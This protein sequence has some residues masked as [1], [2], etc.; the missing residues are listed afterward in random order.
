MKKKHIFTIFITVCFCAIAGLSLLFWKTNFIYRHITKIKTAIT[1]QLDYKYRNAANLDLT[2]YKPLEDDYDAWYTKYHF[3]AHAGGGVEGMVYTQSLEAWEQSY[4]NGVRVFDADLNFTSD[5]QL[6]LRH[7]WEDDLDDPWATQSA[8]SRYWVDLNG[9]FRKTYT[10]SD[11]YDIP[12]YKTFK[13]SLVFNKYNPMTLDDMFSF[14]E[15]YTDAYVSVDYKGDVK[16]VYTQLVNRAL[17][18]DN[19]DDILSRIIVNMYYFEDFDTIN[20]IYPFINHVMREHVIHQVNYSEIIDFC[21]THDV[22]V[23]S[24]SAGYINDPGVELLHQY[25]IRTIVAICDYI[26]D[27]RNYCD[28]GTYMAVSN[29]LYEDDWDVIVSR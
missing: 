18:R 16:E 23:V 9:C 13:S 1:E 2:G 15:R 5:G 17:A 21:I 20:A 12:D 28:N 6:I 8:S 11:C 29:W 19:G 22:H 3:I 4:Q 27:M 24:V 10:N 14:M 26:E 25:G 7:A